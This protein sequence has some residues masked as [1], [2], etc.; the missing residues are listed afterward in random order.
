MKLKE[1]T[2]MAVKAI[3]GFD[4]TLDRWEELSSKLLLSSKL[5]K[6]LNDSTELKFSIIDN[7]H[8]YSL[9]TDNKIVSIIGMSPINIDD[10]KYLYIDFI[11]S[12]PQ[13]EKRGYATG[14]MWAIYTTENT[15][16]LF[17]GAV[18]QKG[19][20]LLKSFLKRLSTENIEM[21][22]IKTF[23]IVQFSWDKYYTKSQYA[24]ILDGGFIESKTALGYWFS[25]TEEFK[26]QL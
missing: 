24:A 6:N 7:K 2:E 15:P 4:I 19:E 17:G 8:C 26:D 18:S 20:Q 11:A 5:I 14:L 12:N 13:E 1:L 10:K 16:L 3:T 21:L 23:K 25:L 22:D 9:W